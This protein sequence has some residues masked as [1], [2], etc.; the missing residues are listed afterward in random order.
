MATRGE[1]EQL[2]EFLDKKF[3][4]L[5]C[6]VEEDWEEDFYVY[7]ISEPGYTPDLQGQ[8]GLQWKVLPWTLPD[9]RANITSITTRI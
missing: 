5:Q 6:F 4:R 7:V 3:P 9:Q 1:A 8:I 2:A